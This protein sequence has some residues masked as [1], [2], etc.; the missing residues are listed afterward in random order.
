M[1]RRRLQACALLLAAGL[2]ER[3]SADLG[4]LLSVVDGDVEVVLPF[5]NFVW[6]W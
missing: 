3:L 1:E 5:V 4:L 6:N 2:G